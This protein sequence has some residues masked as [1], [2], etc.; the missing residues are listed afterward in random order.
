MQELAKRYIKYW[1]C[2]GLR[3]ATAEWSA[4]SIVLFYNRVLITLVFAFSREG[5]NSFPSVCFCRY[6][7]FSVV[8]KASFKSSEKKIPYS[9]GANTQSCLTQLK[10][11]KDFDT[12]SSC[13]T[14]PY[15][16]LWKDSMRLFSFGGHRI[17]VKSLNKPPHKIK[18]FCEIKEWNI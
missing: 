9:V 8:P 17:L 16:L 6:I 2:D 3:A 1:S 7:P 18:I 14:I 15:I 12:F 13:C 10:L 5:L 11:W 4:N